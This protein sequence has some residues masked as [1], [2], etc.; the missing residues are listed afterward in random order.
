MRL[1]V[2]TPKGSAL[3]TDVDEVTAPGVRGEFGV[4]P[5]HT[6]FITALKPGVLVWR[7]KG[8]PRA[9]LAVGAGY[10][11]VSGS[12]R[13]IVLAERAQLATE[14]D[15]AQAE[16]ELDEADRALK[17]HK[18]ESGAPSHESLKAARDWAQARLDARKV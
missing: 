11:E 14:I 18:S 2:V 1:E 16:R 5:G 8:G 17:E 7:Q 9:A 6:P 4:L 13:V 15:A 12:D 10:A 3:V